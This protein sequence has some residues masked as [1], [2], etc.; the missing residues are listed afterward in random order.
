MADFLTSARVQIFLEDCLDALLL[1][2]SAKH[3]AEMNRRMKQIGILRQN[4]RSL[5]R[6]AKVERQAGT[7]HSEQACVLPDPSCG[8][9]RRMMLGGFNAVV[10]VQSV[11]KHSLLNRVCRSVSVLN[12]SFGFVSRIPFAC[13]QRPLCRFGRLSSSRSVAFI[14]RKLSGTR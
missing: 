12:L 6:F 9:F 8:R 14:Q 11:Y 2:L 13:T 5:T 4:H 7:T 10:I 3:K 1:W